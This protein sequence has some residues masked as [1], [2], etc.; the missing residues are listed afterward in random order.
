MDEESKEH[1]FEG[2]V[3]N[4]ERATRYKDALSTSDAVFLYTHALLEDVE[5]AIKNSTARIIISAS[6]S[7]VHLVRG[8]PDAVRNA[9]IYFRYGGERNLR[10]MVHI[11]L[12]SLGVDVA[13]EPVEEV[14]LHGVYHP[15]LGVF[16]NVDEYLDE[17]RR[18]YGSRPMV[19]I[20]F[21][22]THWLSGDTK[23]VD[24]LV[25]A[26]ESEGLGVIP[27][28]TTGWRYEDINSPTKEDSIREFFLRD[29][30][31]RR[32]SVDIFTAQDD[33]HWSEN[34]SK[35]EEVLSELRGR[36]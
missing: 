20:L 19:G 32:G 21:H 24:D 15:T 4:S 9:L 12:K 34:I 7:F 30:E 28:F 5:D 1:A 11:I 14:P 3:V 18:V 23:Y 6:D 31:P 29:G 2:V 22:R 36:R 26:L 25:E 8:D 33:A 13:V 17:Y 10:N 16:E 35:V 27:V